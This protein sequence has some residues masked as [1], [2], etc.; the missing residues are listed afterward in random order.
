MTVAPTQM[1]SKAFL[2][3][4]LEEHLH[5]HGHHL[6]LTA[7]STCRSGAVAAKDDI[8]GGGQ[9]IVLVPLG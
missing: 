3:V 4:L 6:L 7:S 2:Q 1:A 9:L 5:G 8:V